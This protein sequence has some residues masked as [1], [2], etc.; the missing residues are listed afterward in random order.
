MQSIAPDQPQNDNEVF[1][2]LLVNTKHNGV[3]CG[4]GTE[5]P[6]VFLPRDVAKRMM[7]KKQCKTATYVPPGTVV[8]EAEDGDE[9]VKTSK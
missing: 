5:Y 7:L 2:E 4:P 3:K 8:Q 6:K 1:V 9:Q